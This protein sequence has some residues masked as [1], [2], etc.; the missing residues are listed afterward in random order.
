MKIAIASAAAVSNNIQPITGTPVVR[1][2][3]AIDAPPGSAAR[4]RPFNHKNPRMVTSLRLPFATAALL[5]TF[6]AQADDRPDQKPAGPEAP[7]CGCVCPIA[8]LLSPPAGPAAAGSGCSGKD[9]NGR[10]ERRAQLVPMAWSA[11][12]GWQD[13]AL[14]A[15]L[16]PMLKSCTQLRSQVAWQKACDAAQALG[17][18]PTDAAVASLLR[19]QFTPHQIVSGSGDSYGMITGYYEP[20]L[21]G[22]RRPS[23]RFRYPLYTVPEDLVTIELGDVYPELKHRRLRGRLEGNRVVP[24]LSR[25]DIE[26]GDSPPLRGR[27]LCWVEDPVEAFFLQIQGSGQVRLDSGETMRVGYADQNGHPFRSLGRVL[28]DRG[29]ITADRATMPGIRQWARDNPAKVGDFLNTNPSYVFFKELPRELSGPIGTLGVPLTPERSL[30]IDARVVPLGAP[31]YLSTTWPSSRKP[32]Q[33]LMFAQDTGGAINGAVRADFF[34]G[35]G[36][37]AGR[38]AGVMKQ[39]GQMWVLL[40]KGMPPPTN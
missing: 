15:A 30:A 7:A 13:D 10:S 22:S 23:E 32:L 24:Y 27:E 36:D 18:A 4:G 39:S 25:A 16:P 38:L 19:D 5:A 8:P 12:P 34:W 3:G 33:R 11:L 1:P 28:I 35:F 37:D 9:A 2:P 20:L 40:P 14:A 29:E 6:L 26:R 31:V 21:N 17:D